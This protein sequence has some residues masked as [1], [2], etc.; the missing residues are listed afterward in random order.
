MEKAPS[1][2]ENWLCWRLSKTVD[3]VERLQQIRVE[4]PHAPPVWSRVSAIGS[5]D[6]SVQER[7]YKPQ[8][9]LCFL[10]CEHREDVRKWDGK[11]T[12]ALAAQCATTGAILPLGVLDGRRTHSEGQFGSCRPPPASSSQWSCFPARTC[13]A[14]RRLFHQPAHHRDN[15]VLRCRHPRRVS[16][17]QPTPA[18]TQRPRSLRCPP[19]WPAVPLNCRGTSPNRPACRHHLR[20]AAAASPCTEARPQ[21][22]HPDPGSREPLRGCGPGL[23][24][25]FCLPAGEHAA[26]AVWKPCPERRGSN[27]NPR[28][29]AAHPPLAELTEHRAPVEICQKGSSPTAPFLSGRN[30]VYNAEMNA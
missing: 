5:K 16:R 30:R 20:P 6:P 13:F 22:R 27:A 26:A 24:S 19:H 10:V 1:T 17:A 18:C 7:G 3:R 29:F 8:G 9:N 14:L 15:L 12:F 4:I 25:P 21:L 11:P 2:S 28:R 23:D